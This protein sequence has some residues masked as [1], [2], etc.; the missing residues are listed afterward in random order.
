LPWCGAEALK[1]SESGNKDVTRQLQELTIVRSDL[2]AER[3]ALQ[4]ELAEATDANR[5]L[6]ARLDAA[7]AALQQLKTDM[8]NRL[9]DA[10]DEMENIRYVALHPQTTHSQLLRADFTH[11]VNSPS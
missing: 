3:D 6:G 1:E 5:D 7:N 9:R 10:D 11:W 4:S 2:Q 8:E